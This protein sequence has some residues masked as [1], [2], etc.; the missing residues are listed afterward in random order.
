MDLALDVTLS[1]ESVLASEVYRHVDPLNFFKT[2][3]KEGLRPD[4]RKLMA[5]RTVKVE[6]LMGNGNP[7]IDTSAIQISSILLSAGNTHMNCVISATLE[8]NDKPRTTPDLLKDL[9]TVSFVVPKHA[10]TDVYDMNGPC[11]NISH[12]I[13]SLLENVLNSQDVLPKWQFALDYL[14][15]DMED[16]QLSRHII[17]SKLRW[18]LNVSI[19]CEEYD[20]N[21]LDWSVLSAAYALLNSRL[22]VVALS[23]DPVLCT[24]KSQLITRDTVKYVMDG[25]RDYLELLRQNTSFLNKQLVCSDYKD[26]LERFASEN[27]LPFLTKGLS[28]TSL[29][30]TITFCKCLDYIILDPTRE[31]EQIGVNISVY[32]KKVLND[33]SMDVDDGTSQGNVMKMQLLN[34]MGCTGISEDQINDLFRISRSIVSKL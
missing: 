12:L 24:Y 19:T 4:G 34:L 23:F 18:K 29:P 3:F 31:E 17:N 7:N 27:S 20:G 9:V 21:I 5:Y 26:E 11:I 22:P 1:R 6:T 10:A 25:N 33:L 15:K 13:S 32:V 2:F 30:Y 16:D 28:I 14:V 8:C